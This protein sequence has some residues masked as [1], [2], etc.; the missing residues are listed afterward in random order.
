MSEEEAV[1][2]AQAYVAAN[3]LS[4]RTAPI[5]VRRMQA[6]NF[7]SLFGRRVYPSDFWVVEFDKILP[8]G[9]AAEDPGSVLI[10]VIDAGGAVREVQVGMWS[11]G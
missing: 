9:V 2:L 5:G 1:A 6:D 4:V 3:R 10:E 11:D 7:N 8:P